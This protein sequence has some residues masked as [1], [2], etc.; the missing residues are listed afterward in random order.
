[1][2]RLLS[3]LVLS[4]VWVGT[5]WALN[6]VASTPA[7]CSCIAGSNCESHC[8][9]DD[10]LRSLGEAYYVLRCG[11]YGRCTPVELQHC[12]PPNSALYCGPLEPARRADPSIVTYTVIPTC[13]SRL[14]EAMQTMEPYIKKPEKLKQGH[15]DN[16]GGI[17]G[18][19]CM[20][21]KGGSWVGPPSIDRRTLEQRLHD[22]EQAYGREQ[23]SLGRRIRDEASQDWIFSNW[24]QVKK[25]CW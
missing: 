22:A 2:I 11:E 25:E 12:G 4:L 10:S 20:I 6:A 7:S 9:M 19:D 5:G 21:P 24:E 3:A 8:G 1:M 13:E 17:C 15:W 18:G 23:E 14:R 16:G